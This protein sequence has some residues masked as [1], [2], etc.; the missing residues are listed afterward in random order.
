MIVMVDLSG[1][2]LNQIKR[3]IITMYQIVN[4]FS[5]DNPVV[6]QVVA[7]EPIL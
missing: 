3:E 4:E 2:N 7:I 6:A 5:H 1:F